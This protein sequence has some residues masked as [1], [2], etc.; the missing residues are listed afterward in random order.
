M[1]AKTK[2]TITELYE[3][4]ETKYAEDEAANLIPL[5]RMVD[6]FIWCLRRGKKVNAWSPDDAD[7]SMIIDVDDV[8]LAWCDL[9]KLED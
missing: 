2:P 6:F 5:D 9:L 4:L 7:G 3:D 8:S 1:T